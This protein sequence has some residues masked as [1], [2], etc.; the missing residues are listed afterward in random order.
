MKVNDI[1]YPILFSAI[2]FPNFSQR[3]IP[4]KETDVPV[5]NIIGKSASSTLSV[6]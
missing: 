3:A 1:D 2:G 5:S 4:I 6:T